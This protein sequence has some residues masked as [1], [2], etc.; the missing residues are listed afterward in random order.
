[1]ELLRDERTTIFKEKNMKS[2]PPLPAI[3]VL[4]LLIVSAVVYYFYFANRPAVS[5]ELAAS[6]SMEAI[7]VSIAPEVSGKVINVNAETG[8]TVKLGD[9]L[10]QLDDSILKAQRE[11]AQ[12]TLETVRAAADTASAAVGVA[13]A[14][15]DS[16]LS[17]A[18]ADDKTNRTA[19]WNQTKPS[20]FQENSWYFTRG[21]QYVALQAD[22]GKAQEALTS[23]QNNLKFVQDKSTSGDFLNAE[24]R[25]VQARVAYQT[26]ET[27]LER[28]GSAADSQDLRDE[29]Q[30]IFDDAKS[31]LDDAE[32]AYADALTTEGAAD[33][34]QARA[35]LLVAQERVDTIA[36][37]LRALQTG[38]LSPKVVSAQKSLDQALAAAA[39][40]KLAISQ[41]ESNLKLIDTQISR[42]VIT[43]PA[44]GTILS[45]NVE[46]GEVV[47]PGSVV[48]TLGRLAEL[49][50]TVFIPEDRYGE[51]SLGQAVNVVADSF[52]GVI[53]KG[54]V[55]EISDKAEF[56][57]RN[58]QTTEGRKSTVFAIKIK[59]SDPEGKLKPGMPADVTFK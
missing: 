31:E 37:K 13:Q 25:L 26:A 59:V 18:L 10:F 12:A 43:S 27:L 19:D 49:T 47:S 23:A 5:T 58:V 28:A 15:Y 51:I 50:L 20:D 57:P 29:A 17:T 7:S 56:T 36:D 22:A 8:Q 6:G 46:P 42:L 39:Q 1:L 40:A 3:I 48:F 38:L 16:I 32:T 54:S 30:N 45:R 11:S 52:P 35:K 44:D 53:F 55:T 24:K 33:L 9:V 14:Q 41:A 2:R 21:E 4:L 34:I